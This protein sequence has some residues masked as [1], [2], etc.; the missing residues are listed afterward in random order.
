MERGCVV[1]DEAGETNERSFGFSYQGT[2]IEATSLLSAAK[3]F[4]LSP[5][6]RVGVRGK[7]A[8]N[9][10][11]A[12]NSTPRSPSPLIPLPWGEGNASFPPNQYLVPWQHCRF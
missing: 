1:L 9:I 8:G 11:R 3:C 2:T 7:S 12:V 4:S 6:E 5:R 10:T